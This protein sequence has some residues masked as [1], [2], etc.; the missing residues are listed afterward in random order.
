MEKSVKIGDL[1]IPTDYWSMD[2]DTKRELCLTIVDAMLTL[3]DK[4]VNPE[5]NRLSILNTILD[6][7]IET[8]E[9]DENYEVCQVLK[10]IKTII[11][12]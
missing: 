8:N 5:F 12:E 7:S 2:V 9:K 1:E 4:L 11:N 10:D 3:L 6:S